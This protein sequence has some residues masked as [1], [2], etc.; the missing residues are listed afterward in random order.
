[1]PVDECELS[2][3][4]LMMQWY[5]IRQCGVVWDRA[6]YHVCWTSRCNYAKRNFGAARCEVGCSA[7]SWLDMI[8]TG[9]FV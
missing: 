3:V 6:G 5:L 9:A 7:G 4:T 2:D 1:M 8:I